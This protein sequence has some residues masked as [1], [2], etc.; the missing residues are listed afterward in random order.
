VRRGLRL[1]AVVAGLALVAELAGRLIGDRGGGAVA[2]AA[3]RRFV[4]DDLADGGVLASTLLEYVSVDL[5]VKAAPERLHL[6]ANTA[7]YRLA[8]IEERTG[9]DVRRLADVLDLVIAVQ[10]ARGAVG[11]R[12]A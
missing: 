3:I 11:A 10:S 4:S 12:A 9:C 6:H 2:T 5:N 7:H 1:T 8:R